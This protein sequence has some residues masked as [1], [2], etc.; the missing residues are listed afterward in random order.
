MFLPDNLKDQSQKDREQRTKKAFAQIE[1]WAT[2]LIPQSARDGVQFSVQEFECNS[3]GCSPVD[4]AI[5]I[6]FPR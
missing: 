1:Q 5:A 2:E 6:T 3:D 4:T